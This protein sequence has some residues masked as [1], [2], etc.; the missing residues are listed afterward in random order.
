MFTRFIQTLVL[1]LLA[2]APSAAA[3]E[4]PVRFNGRTL[5][6]LSHGIGSFTAQERAN[7]VAD[8]LTRL[9]RDPE[10]NAGRLTVTDGESSSDIA[11]GGM[12][13]L[14][15]T[16]QDAA[17]S[18]RSRQAMA[19]EDARILESALRASRR[20]HSIKSLFADAA[21]GIAVSALLVA[22]LWLLRAGFGRLRSL[23]D[24][25]LATRIRDVRIQR[26]QLLPAERVLW[27]LTGAARGLYGLAVVVILYFYIVVVLSIFPATRDFA[28]W[29][30][31]YVNSGLSAVAG[32]ISGYA[33]NLFTILVIAV[34][35]RYAIRLCHFLF[36]G[37]ESGNLTIAGFYREWAE[38]TYK[39]VRFLMLAVAVILVYPYIPG[40]DS[41]AFRGLSIFIG[42]LVSLGSAGA[43]G[44]IVSGVL[45]TYTRAF[46]AGD[47]VRIG[48]TMGDIV[49]RNLLATRVRTIKN[50]D[51]TVPNSMVLSS[52]IVNYTSCCRDGAL[53]LYTTVTIGY[54]APWR[55]VHEL[56]ISAALAT[57]QVLR[58]PPPF[59]LQTALSDFY[60][61]YQI[62]AYTANPGEMVRIYSDLHQ[63]IQDRFNEAGVEIC[64]PHFAAL[65][66]ANRIAIPDDYV[67]GTYQ[68]PSFRV[69]K[70]GGGAGA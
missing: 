22:V 43:V 5:F 65:R 14:S 21:L 15:V 61:N 46:R 17:G 25:R 54:D 26:L 58:E 44:N 32:A 19:R 60:V 23:I 57:D 35:T 62:N 34:A 66:D 63:N 53:I 4:V 38:P 12:V 33:P 6:T 42:V 56:L 69:T 30:F 7:A 9:T 18:G 28:T 68:A 27:L 3:T 24:A 64:S 41:P 39:I 8:R 40:H 1:L 48:E 47:R 55:Q 45:L 20:E 11:A 50:E 59:V 67:P 49:E 2:A 36:Q 16:D 51:V 37:V 52:H 31:T 10:T 13:I 29:I 70:T